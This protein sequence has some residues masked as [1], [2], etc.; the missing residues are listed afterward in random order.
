MIFHLLGTSPWILKSRVWTLLIFIIFF[1]MLFLDSLFF[2]SSS[3]SCFFLNFQIN[4]LL[5]FKDDKSECPCPE[6]IRDQLLDFHEDLMTHCGRVFLTYNS[7]W[8]Y[9]LVHIYWYKSSDVESLE[10]YRDQKGIK[11]K[12]NTTN[13][14]FL[15]RLLP[16]VTQGMGARNQV[17]LSK[18]E[19]LSWFS[20]KKFVHRLLY[21]NWLRGP[22]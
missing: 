9:I 6:E 20:L 17:L 21:F 19:V 7:S 22:F 1:I 12:Q 8:I 13:I 14:L 18:R 4:M 15:F 2:Y 5:N 3:S 11:A 10:G 16:L